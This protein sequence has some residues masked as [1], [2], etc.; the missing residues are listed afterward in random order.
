LTIRCAMQSF[1]DRKIQCP[2]TWTVRQLKQHLFETFLSKPDPQRQ[3]LIYAGHCLKDAQIVSEILEKRR[4]D[5]EPSAEL[6]PQVIHLV[7]ASKEVPQTLPASSGLRHRANVT[8]L[9]TNRQPTTT[10]VPQQSPFYQAWNMSQQFSIPANASHEQIAYYTNWMNYQMMMGWYQQQFIA[11]SGTMPFMQTGPYNV[12]FNL[13][14]MGANIGNNVPGA[15]IPEAQDQQ[16]PQINNPMANGEEEHVNDVL[17]MIYKSIRVGFFLMI[18][19]FYSSVERFIAVFLII[20]ILWYIHRRR[21]QNNLNE[22][23]RR[24]VQ[25][26]QQN[27]PTPEPPNTEVNA[28]GNANDNNNNEV[29]ALP[30]EQQQQVLRLAET[31]TPWNLFWST[32]SSFFLS[33]IPENPREVME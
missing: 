16:N 18:L 5:L 22:A 11:Q 8:S 24:I 15:Q 1:E 10:N 23:A 29:P 17:G 7:C 20:C 14:G 9:T 32:V 2:P 33:L 28:E 25:G 19:F 31:Q 27:Q 26:I 30:R 21:E 6:G 13:Q 3:R 4:D 12:Q